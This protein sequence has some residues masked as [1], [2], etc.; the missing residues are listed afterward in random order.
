MK[1]RSIL[2]G[3]LLV[4]QVG[5]GAS[6]SEP[7]ADPLEAA[8]TQAVSPGPVLQGALNR[9]LAHSIA[10]EEARRTLLLSRC[11]LSNPG[12]RAQRPDVAALAEAIVGRRIEMNAGN[13][14]QA[15]LMRAIA[16]RLDFLSR[17]PAESQRLM[18]FLATPEGARAK[19]AA[20]LEAVILM[21]DRY[22]VDASTGASWYW[23]VGRLMLVAKEAG[24]HAQ[25][26]AALDAAVPGAAE[27]ALATSPDPAAAIPDNAAGLLQRVSWEDVARHLAKAYP[28]DLVAAR[29]KLDDLGFAGRRADASQAMNLMWRVDLNPAPDW[30]DRS[31]KACARA[32]GRPCEDA[33][34][35][36]LARMAKAAL[37]IDDF[38]AM[39]AVARAHLNG[40]CTFPALK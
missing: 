25:L 24:W 33:D 12:N 14:S 37:E 3:A 9:I 4:L 32:R 40:S 11:D 7:V 17:P 16:Q 23:P 39:R 34:T 18:A 8:Y 27:A 28:P 22:L 5:S 36:E 29:D 35:R 15:G 38:S 20:E 6:A 26:L 19:Q 21:L 30:A 2:V 10:L 31:I 1:A 13:S